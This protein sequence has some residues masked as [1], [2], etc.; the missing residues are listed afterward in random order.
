M[1][2]KPDIHFIDEILSE[3][4]KVIGSDYEAYRNHIIRMVSIC[5][6]LKDCNE[7]EQQKIQIAA[8]FHDIGLWTAKTLDY[9]PPSL[10]PTCDYLKR[11][12]LEAWSE[13]IEL[14]ITEH[15]K[16]KPYSDARYPHVELFRK[17]DLVDFSLGCFKF[18]L[19]R[20]FIKQLKI[21]YPNAGFHKTLVKKSLAWFVRHPLNPAPMFKW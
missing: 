17:G 10:P 20:Q 11:N 5:F 6:A 18:G 8:C 21:N 16:L 13:E 14:M 7:E 2:N 12:N 1:T 3:W 19:S 9:L 15:H 4:Q